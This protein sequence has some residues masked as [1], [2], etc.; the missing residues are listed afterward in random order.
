MKMKYS[1]LAHAFTLFWSDDL[2]VSSFGIRSHILGSNLGEKNIFHICFNNHPCSNKRPSPG[3]DDKMAIW[4]GFF[5]NFKASN[6]C[7]LQK[8]EK[9]RFHL[10]LQ[11]LEF[12]Y[13]QT[14]ITT[15]QVTR[16]P[17]IHIFKFIDLVE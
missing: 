14:L 7:P 5:G 2:V 13:Y 4:G 9:K 1:N 15:N 6:K 11:F 3:L 10:M 12:I 17:F 8:M 16:W